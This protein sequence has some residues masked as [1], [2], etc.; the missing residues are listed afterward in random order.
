MS[1]SQTSK[2]EWNNI[3]RKESKRKG[4]R[5][6]QNKQREKKEDQN[7]VGGPMKEMRNLPK[8]PFLKFS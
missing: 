4:E 5:N 3:E 6:K 7:C 1:L 8:N 2:V